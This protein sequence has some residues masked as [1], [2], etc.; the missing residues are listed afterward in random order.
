MT[1]H[2]LSVVAFSNVERGT[3]AMTEKCIWPDC[4]CE[5]KC[6]HIACEERGRDSERKTDNSGSLPH[7]RIYF[8]RLRIVL[9]Y[10][11]YIH[12]AK[13]IP[14]SLGMDDAMVVYST[15]N[16]SML[17]EFPAPLTLERG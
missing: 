2:S 16:T 17:V 11:A 15:N 10:L 3:Y 4:D 14:E 13:A 6:D 8:R 7:Y 1:A 9:D 5:I 12:D